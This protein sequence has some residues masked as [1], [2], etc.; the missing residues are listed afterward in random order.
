MGFSRQERWSGLP[1]PSPV[2][3]KVTSILGPLWITVNSSLVWTSGLIDGNSKYLSFQ[4]PR[5]S[6]ITTQL[7]PWSTNS[8]RQYMN[9]WA[10]QCPNKTLFITLAASRIWLMDCSLQTPAPETCSGHSQC[11]AEIPFTSCWWLP[12][13]FFST[14]ASRAFSTKKLLHPYAHPMGWPGSVNGWLRGKYRKPATCFK[15]ETILWYNWC[16]RVPSGIRQKSRSPI[17]SNACLALSLSQ[18]CFLIPLLLR[19]SLGKLNP[20]KPLS[21]ALLLGN[22]TWDKTLKPILAPYWSRLSL[23]AVLCFL[24]LS[25]PVRMWDS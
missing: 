14:L 22:S 23:L 21:Q 2:Q 5:V 19:A 18:S 25:F 10:C 8:H 1:C 11:P 6:I 15:A 7:C 3:R 12:A 24:G 17:K 20:P 13:A 4:S 16:S 9:K